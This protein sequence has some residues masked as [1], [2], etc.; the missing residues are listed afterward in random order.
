MNAPIRTKID[1]GLT[2]IEMIIVIVMASMVGLMLTTIM[3][4]ALEKSGET[5]KTVNK[6]VDAEK[7]METITA[8]YIRLNNLTPTTAIDTLK[9]YIENGNYTNTSLGADPTSQSGWNG[10]LTPS[11]DILVVIV[12]VGGKKL[13]TMFTESRGLASATLSY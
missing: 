7:I 9:T 5:I 3:T 1:S 11:Q 2:L 6:E 4:T 8:D 13:V 12:D 10:T